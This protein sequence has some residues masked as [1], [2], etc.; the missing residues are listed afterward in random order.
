MTVSY[1][2]LESETQ[3]NRHPHP[4]STTLSLRKASSDRSNSGDDEAS[5]RMGGRK[6]G[7]LDA[8]G[9]PVGAKAGA[10]GWLF[11]RGRSKPDR[12]I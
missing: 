7:Y 4:V 8:G 2:H 5:G 10:R 12:A 1:T 9:G 6:L 11:R 3:C